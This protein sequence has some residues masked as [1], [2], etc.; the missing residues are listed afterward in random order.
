VV[1][2]ASG[3][4]VGVAGVVL[5]LGSCADLTVSWMYPG[6]PSE[7]DSRMLFYMRNSPVTS[8]IVARVGLTVGH[9]VLER[10]DTVENNEA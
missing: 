2:L 10:V 8:C 4:S 9:S 3:L 6:R 7:L 5:E 1:G